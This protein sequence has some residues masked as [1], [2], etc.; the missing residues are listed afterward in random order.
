M[1]TLSTLHRLLKE[2]QQIRQ[3]VAKR[4]TED[5]LKPSKNEPNTEV[6]EHV[7]ITWIVDYFQI[8][9]GTFYNEVDGQLLDPILYIGRRPYYLK[10]D[11]LALMQERKKGH[12]R[13]KKLNDR[14][15]RKNK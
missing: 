3:L 13:F 15:K 12:L 8:S 4:F 14:R 7:D 10:S 1:E 5:P 9:K 6:P 11:V 2:V